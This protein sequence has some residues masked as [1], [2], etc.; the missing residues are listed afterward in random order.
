MPLTS[1]QAQ[2][3]A[4]AA[5][6]LAPAGP[7]EVKLNGVP[8]QNPEAKEQLLT[9]KDEKQTSTAPISPSEVVAQQSAEKSQREPIKPDSQRVFR[10][11]MPEI[12]ANLKYQ[13]LPHITQAHHYLKFVPEVFREHPIFDWTDKDYEYTNKDIHFLRALN[14]TISAGTLLCDGVPIG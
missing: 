8:R 7:K 11:A 6:G 4:A 3:E 5:A 1:K 9:V 12:K 2:A 13:K 10:P 14:K